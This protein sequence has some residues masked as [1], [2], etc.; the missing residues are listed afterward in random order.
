MSCTKL[1]SWGRDPC[2]CACVLVRASLCEKTRLSAVLSDLWFSEA[3]RGFV[4]V[5]AMTRQTAEPEFSGWIRCIRGW[6]GSRGCIWGCKWM[7]ACRNKRIFLE[8]S[9]SPHSLL[10]GE[11][12]GKE[13]GGEARRKGGVNLFKWVGKDNERERVREKERERDGGLVVA[14]CKSYI[15]WSFCFSCVHLA[16]ISRQVGSAKNWIWVCR[17]VICKMQDMTSIFLHDL[18]NICNRLSK[19][20]CMFW[21]HFERRERNLSIA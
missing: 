18:I 16:R 2:H 14:L 19:K 10:R 20:I 7:R 6:V 21:G 9:L 11:K 12:W 17:F 15:S 3:R 13:E 4:V 5:L 8:L 1:V